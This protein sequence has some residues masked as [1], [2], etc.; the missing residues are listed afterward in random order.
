[1]LDYASLIRAAAG[2]YG[3]RIA[4]DDPHASYTFRQVH[5][6]TSALAGGFRAT[7][8]APGDAV[9]WLSPNT[10]THPL[11]H[12]AAAKAGLVFSPLNYYLRPGELRA[13]ADVVKPRMILAH[14]EYLDTIGPLADELGVEFRFLVDTDASH[15]P[16]RSWLDLHAEVDPDDDFGGHSDA[17]HE[18][19]FTSGTTGQVKGAARTQRQRILEAMVSIIVNP[20]GKRA[21]V[22][23]GSPQFHVG[24]STGPLQT[25][26]QGGRTTFYK[27][28]PADMVEHI[29]AGITH[30]AG[31]PAQYSILF[32]SGLL[33]GV[34]TSG[35]RS[36]AIA[37]NAAP[38]AL[39]RQVHEAFPHAQLA[40]HYGSTESGMTTAI[41]DQE[42]LDHPLSIGRTAPGVEL[43]IVDVDGLDV[44]DG[45]VG[46]LWVRSEF[47]M[48]GYL[49]RDDLTADART[50][51]GF[52]RMGD[53]G[54]RED[55]GFVY[56]V[57]RKKDM[58]ITGGENVYPKEVEDVIAEL[59][60][61][62]EV[63]VVGAP[64]PV[65]EERVVAVVR[66]VA[67]HADE[68]DARAETV[69]A[70]VRQ[71]LAGY[72]APKDVFFVDDFPR[73]ALGKIDKVALR[74]QYEAVAQG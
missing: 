42:F 41:T 45:E 23:R 27:F 15:G 52:L 3:S 4:V 74:R 55:D 24:A 2:S 10:V 31:V 38:P 44:A 20:Q 62:A 48:T 35:V 37:S 46:E 69:V 1:M 40:H 17:L 29:R 18:V 68:S 30:I 6:V 53:L 8:M 33:E 14:P 57:G 32:D 7:G 28:R 36:C 72:K 34:D 64:D 13:A 58:I 43:R 61:V 21:H 60:F 54:R 47:S 25:L 66:P 19:I 26:L 11:A 71:R 59:D 73:N 50:D 49:R 22:L 70:E 16:W 39:I 51:D 65:F 67:P 5:E 12:W 56:I 63:A 9:I